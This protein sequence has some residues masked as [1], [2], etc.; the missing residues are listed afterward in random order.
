MTEECSSIIQRKPPFKVKDPG[1]F[2]LLV[3]FEGKGATSGLIDLGASVNL[4]PLSM[5]ER[6]KIGELKGTMMQLQL[7]DR[8]I[9]Y[10]RGVCEDVL[11][12][13]GKFE[14]PTYFVII[15]ISEEASM[16]LIFRR[17]FL[18]TAKTKIDVDKG[19]IS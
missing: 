6:L 12:K 1:R 11:V 15:D 7:A 10:P 18:A 19:M 8:S 16:P 2:A 9:I 13:V 3:E 4:M 14:F 5:F 17:P